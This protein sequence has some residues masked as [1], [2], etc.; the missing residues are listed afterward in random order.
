LRIIS[1]SVER[2]EVFCRVPR[3]N[4]REKDAKK[5]FSWSRVRKRGWIG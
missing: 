2:M 5:W 3:W 1:R 4:D